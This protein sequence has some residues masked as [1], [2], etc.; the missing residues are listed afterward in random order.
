MKF[1]FPVLPASFDLPERG[2]SG[3]PSEGGDPVENPVDDSPAEGSGGDERGPSGAASEG[4]GDPTGPP[5][6]QEGTPEGPP[7]PYREHPYRAHPYEETPPPASSGA[8]V[9]DVPAAPDEPSAKK[10]QGDEFGA[11][12]AV[13]NAQPDFGQQ[14]MDAAAKEL[15]GAGMR[16]LVIRAAQL[17]SKGIPA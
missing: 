10:D 2:P 16:A 7:N 14:A 17:A 1:R 11:A 3:A 6:S 5:L 15:P 4:R 9:E 12:R 13:L 8:E